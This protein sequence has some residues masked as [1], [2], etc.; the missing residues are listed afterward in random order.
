MATTL[1]TQAQCPGESC[2]GCGQTV[3]VKV[4]QA[5]GTR[6][7]APCDALVAQGW[8]GRYQAVLAS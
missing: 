2:G 1:T 7:F 8:M 6:S 4:N 5:K 3:T